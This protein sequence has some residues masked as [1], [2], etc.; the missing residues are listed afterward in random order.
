MLKAAGFTV[1]L[2]NGME[3]ATQINQITNLKQFDIGC[4]GFSMADEA[5]EVIFSLAFNAAAAGNSMNHQ[6]T[7]IDAGS[8]LLREAKTDAERQAALDKIQDVWR[9][10]TPSVI[11]AATPERIIWNKSVNGIT[12]NVASTVLWHNVWVN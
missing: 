3:T 6:I 11:L 4:W 5:P 12:P 7:D 2:T 10:E 8:K 9:A 1:N